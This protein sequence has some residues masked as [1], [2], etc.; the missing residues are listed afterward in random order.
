V[1][2]G[3]GAATLALLAA[4]MHWPVLATPLDLAPLPL[5]AWGIALACSLACVIGVTVL[6]QRISIIRS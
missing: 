3:L 1:A 5:A 6:T 4:L 2:W